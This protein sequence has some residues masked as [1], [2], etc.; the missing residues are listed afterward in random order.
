ML[1]NITL[2]RFFPG[3]SF[4]HKLDPRIKIVLM[5]I[6]LIAA[7]LSTN[8]MSLFV[9]LM[10][11][12]IFV[13]LTKISLRTYIKS[14][15]F[16]LLVVL[17]TSVLNVFY[18]KGTPIFQVGPVVV[19]K[20]GLDNSIFVSMRLIMLILISS[21]LTFTTSPTD[22]TDALERL[23]KPLAIFKVKTHELAMMMTIALRFIPTLFE[24]MNKIIDAQKA[25]GADMENG[26]ILSRIKAFAPVLIPLFVSS[27]KRAYDLALAMECRCYRGGEGRTRMKIL[28]I[29]PQDIWATIVVLFVLMLVLMCNMC[30]PAVVL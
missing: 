28:Q 7:F 3:D 10:T 21:L 13:M 15:R 16:I 30:I 12:F 14:M 18:A 22:L 17:F 23:I 27:F 29:R 24:E 1:N 9:N 25:R 5:I 4:V 11:T 19:T 26:N 20:E 2:G 6:L 8:Y